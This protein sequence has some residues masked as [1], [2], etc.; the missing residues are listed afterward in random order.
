MAALMSAQAATIE[1]RTINP[2]EN[3]VRRVTEPPNH[4]TSPYA[5]RMMVKFLK[6]VYTGTE[7]NWI[8]LEPV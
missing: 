7:R 3:S 2:K 1:D 8:A 6:I 4:R 5:I